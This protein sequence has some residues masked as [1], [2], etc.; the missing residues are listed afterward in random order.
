MITG[1]LKA[2]HDRRG[3]N[4]IIAPPRPPPTN[5]PKKENITDTKKMRH[6]ETVEKKKTLH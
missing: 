5:P 6:V 3:E 1:S 4:V 2:Q